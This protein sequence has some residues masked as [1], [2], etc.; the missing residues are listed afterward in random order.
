[1]VERAASPRLRISAVRGAA[2][3]LALSPRERGYVFLRRG[4]WRQV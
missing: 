1:M 3:T 2:L 4:V